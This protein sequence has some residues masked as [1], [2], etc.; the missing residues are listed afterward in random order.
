MYSGKNAKNQFKIFNK[1]NGFMSIIKLIVSVFLLLLVAQA[2]A[3]TSPSDHLGWWPAYYLR[4]AINQKWGLNSDVQL[5]NFADQPILGLLALRTGLHYNLNK[6]WSTAI[7]FAWFHYEFVND[8]KRSDAEELRLWQEVKHDWKLNKWQIVNRFRTEQRHWT[9]Q[10]GTAFRFRY[11]LAADYRIANKWKAMAGNELMWQSGKLRKTW[12]QDRLWLGSEYA[13][14]E[15]NQVQLLFM[16][17]WQFSAKTYQ[18]VIRINFVQS[19]N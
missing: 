1:G 15:K 3:Q 4:Y 16:N 2:K 6:Q 10:D 12:D 7:G 5:R 13:I 9:N 19:I 17:W 14:N 18:P 8:K 11:Y